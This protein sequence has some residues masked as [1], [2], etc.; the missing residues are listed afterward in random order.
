MKFGY[1]V[2]L[3]DVH[4]CILGVSDIFPV[5]DTTYC[6]HQEECADDTVLWFLIFENYLDAKNRWDVHTKNGAALS[7]AV[8]GLG[9]HQVNT[10]CQ[11]TGK[12][13]G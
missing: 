11:S 7:G 2:R 10:I 13:Y 9:L 12:I 1:V 6:G 3:S 8:D 5:P 4:V